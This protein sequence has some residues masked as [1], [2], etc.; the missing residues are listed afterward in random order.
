MSFGGFVRPDIRSKSLGITEFFRFLLL[1]C[2]LKL[3]TICLTA[4][5]WLLMVR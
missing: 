1:F 4:G 2:G 3:K 5:V